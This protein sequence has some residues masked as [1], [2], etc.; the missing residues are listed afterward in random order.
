MPKTEPADVLAHAAVQHA[1]G[2]MIAEAARL[3]GVADKHGQKMRIA[4]VERIA[5][6]SPIDSAIRLV[7]AVQETTIFERD[8]PFPWQEDTRK[9][10]LALGLGDHARPVSCHEVIETMILPRINELVARAARAPE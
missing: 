4:I 6:G 8:N 5:E 9:L 10:L 3:T 1:I 7:N 2:D